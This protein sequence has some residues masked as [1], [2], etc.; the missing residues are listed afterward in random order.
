MWQLTIMITVECGHR[1][2]QAHW[3]GGAA[4]APHRCP[5]CSLGP[6]VWYF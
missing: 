2:T 3:E 5:M 4:G 1:C 6:T